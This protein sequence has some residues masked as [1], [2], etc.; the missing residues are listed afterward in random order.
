[1]DKDLIVGL[2]NLSKSL[3]K[4][5]DALSKK[6]D[7]KTATAAALQMGR[8][9]KQ[10]RQISSSI[11]NVKR[12]TQ[13]IL[14]QQDTILKILKRK[15]KDVKSKDIQET[16]VKVSKDKNN[17]KNID[18]KDK[19]KE[20]DSNIS[21]KPKEVKEIPKET[22]IVKVSKDK[23][24]EKDSISDKPKEVKEIPK[25]TTIVK[26]SKD[27]KVEKD[28]NISDKPKEVNEIPKETTIV[29]VSKDKKIDS[30]KVNEVPKETTVVKV[31]KDVSNSEKNTKKN[32]G[33]FGDIDTKKIKDGISTVLIIASALAAIGLSLKIIGKVDFT[34]VLALTLALPLMAFA[35]ERISRINLDRKKV[36]DMI[37]ALVGFSTAITLSSYV[38]S[39]IK[40]VGL[41]QSIT[42]IMISGAFAII[43][44]NFGKLLNG[45]KDV[46]FLT[47]AKSVIFLPIIMVSLSMAIMYSSKFLSNVKP[48]GLFQAVSA[49]MISGVFAVIS[50]GIGKLL[51]G[52]KGLNPITAIVAST[53]LPIVLVSISF[54]IMASSA[55]LSRVKPIGLF[56]AITSIMIAGVFSVI[57]YGIGK[58]LGGFKGISPLTAIAASA[59]IPIVFIALS[60]AIMTSSNFL[61][62]VT[63]I[64]LFQ[65]ISSILI[66]ATFVV[67]SYAVAKIL[68]SF[69]KVNMADAVKASIIMPL[70]FTSMSISIMLSSYVLSKVRPIG[71]FQF[72]S[73]IGISL[74]FVAFAYTMKLIV[75]AIKNI[76]IK[77][78]ISAFAKLTIMV[79]A[80]ALTGSI[81]SKMPDI[82]LS[83]TLKA[84]AFTGGLFVIALLFNGIIKAVG[85]ISV[86]NIVKGGVVIVAIAAVIMVSS[87]LLSVG[88]YKNYP[89]LAWALGV[90][91]S[92]AAFGLGAVLLG[93]QVLNP[94]F[95]DGLGVILLVAATVVATSY[96][97]GSGSYDKYPSFS[98]VGS[99][100]LIL[101]SFGLVAV[102]LGVVSPL[103]LLGLPAMLGVAGT[104]YLIDKIFS[105][106]GYKKYPTNDWVNPSISLIGRFAGMAILYSFA[107][108]LIILGGLSILAVTGTILLV[109][110]IFGKG[111]FKSYPST[112]WMSGVSNTLEIFSKL[113][114]D[115]RRDLGFGDLILGAIKVLGVVY[116]IK[117]M[118]DVLS[119]GDFKKFP[120]KSWNDGVGYSIRTFMELMKEKSFWDV[121][122]EKIG[123]FFGGG[124]DDIATGMVKIDTIL[125]K[126]KFDKYPSSDWTKNVIN[127]I[128]SFKNLMAETGMFDKIGSGISDFISG[129]DEGSLSLVGIADQIQRVSYTLSIGNYE[130]YPSESW[131]K[132]IQS[133]FIKFLSLGNMASKSTFGISNILNLTK[134]I[135]L[136]DL[137]F[138]KGKFNRY[139]DSKWIKNS[140]NAILE[141]GKLIILSDKIFPLS[142]L[143]MGLI[144]DRLIVE[145]ILWLDK[146]LSLGK[147]QKYPNNKWLTETNNSILYY[148][149]L[150]I[151]SNKEFSLPSLLLGIMK[152]N[153]IVDSIISIDKK[154]ETGKYQRYPD[155]SWIDKTFSSILEYGKLS[156]NVDKKFGLISLIL[157]LSKIRKIADTIQQVSL[158]LSRGNYTK[159]PNNQWSL[160]VPG[161]IKG[162]MSFNFGILSGMLLPDKV[163]KNELGKIVDL[164]LF[165]DKKFQSGNWQK[166]PSV[167]WVNGT[168]LSLQ[169]FRSIISLLS[170]S[171][172]GD[173]VL[174]S[175]GSNNPIVT[176]VSNI[177]KLAVSFEKLS[178][179]IKSFTDS[180]KNIDGDKLSAIRSLS[181]NV[182]M[183][184]LMD[185][186]QFDA[187]MDKLEKR[188]GVFADLVKDFESKK[189]EV[190]KTSGSIG[191]SY[192]TSKNTDSTSKT[193]SQILSEKLDLMNS[194]LADIT[195]VVGS[196][197]TLKNYLNR[198]KDDVSIGG[199]NTLSHRSD[200]RVKNIIKKYGVSDSGI[201]IYLFT[202]HFDPCTIY[203]GIIAQELIGTK[204]EK[205]LHV[206]SSGLYSVDYSIIDVEFKKTNL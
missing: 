53:L 160:G 158:S 200:K 22:T 99:T 141:Y 90:G 72:L 137:L 31:S 74:V 18:S 86:S 62:K 205:A 111:T 203:Q 76:S 187:M 202:Y 15:E 127:T 13:K 117:Q 153:L 23:K 136:I 12:D 191:V 34:S 42:A 129:G 132:S 40:P 59:L 84:V 171:S 56:Q 122:G 69:R 181:T 1:M 118:D 10:L 198:I 95:Y 142:N 33:I 154:I 189:T 139:P 184:S 131:T 175:F 65:A 134:S 83:K 149:R 48:I 47:L 182:I 166:F 97:L 4:I 91:L 109:D 138:S 85:N 75:N 165:V 172:L 162:F 46:N 201:N 101:G 63:P 55:L 167:Q 2:S 100:I 20:K 43:A 80:I 87:L 36:P 17:E 105:S 128:R 98:W 88:K 30:N 199:Q 106:G 144:K 194:F 206:D 102:G 82:N 193:E 103:L 161:A 68:P 89:G 163:E 70:L 26:V 125:S 168:I 92:L 123:S 195:S 3:D 28:S 119:K 44:P 5:A 7:P 58:I 6:K 151:K 45:F 19:V 37:L 61:S 148:G 164:M 121:I 204:Y 113:L 93:T 126:G 169:K 176:A 197:G 152:V 147:Y 60:F 107:L 115:I 188:S 54:A 190:N 156:I 38:L 94:F 64:G 96:I 177:E 14:D 21:N 35:F 50:Y 135:L 29:K 104:I 81:I 77:D 124:L 9:D 8:F 52:F 173:G 185:P 196:R 49:I 32:P 178:K 25:E 170:F 108:P 180:I 174:S 27:K 183:M 57:S 120:N 110:K 130:R 112:K 192:K 67:L 157:G 66:A 146:K 51:S 16:I 114:K 143:M 155:K 71:V 41:F 39:L 79:V 145:N 11:T 150:F 24:V 179:S 186:T 73:A 133:I 140:S 78:T 116:T 159:F